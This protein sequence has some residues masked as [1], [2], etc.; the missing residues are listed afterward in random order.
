M[1]ALIITGIFNGA[2]SGPTMQY[3]SDT[4]KLMVEMSG[5][6]TIS[7]VGFGSEEAC[8]VQQ[9][10]ASARHLFS[11]NGMRITVKSVECR[12]DEVKGN[13]PKA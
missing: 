13:G 1:W 9:A 11:M 3:D 12:Q 4:V 7:Q 2:V 5:D 10:A 8:K 6:I